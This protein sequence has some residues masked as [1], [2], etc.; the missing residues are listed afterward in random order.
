VIEGTGAVGEVRPAPS[1]VHTTGELDLAVAPE[2]DRALDAVPADID[3]IIDLGATTFVDS[4]ILSLFVRN[5]RSHS[6][7]GSTLVLAAPA[8]IVRRVLATTRLDDV[9]R[10]TATL[11][12]ARTLIARTPND[13]A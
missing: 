9:L 10:C 6:D 13:G 11:D 7:H 1:V 2:L 3:L 5:A 8:P 4:V 12:D